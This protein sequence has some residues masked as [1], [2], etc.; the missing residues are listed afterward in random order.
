MSPP[1]SEELEAI[2]IQLLLEAVFRRYG[3]DFRNY[4]YPSIRRRV[5]STV[6]MEG[7]QT[8]SEL[9]GKLLHD[10]ACMERFLLAVSINVTTMFRDA[11]FY[12]AFQRLEG[13]APHRWRQARA[14]RRT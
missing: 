12:R 11:S 6:Y 5:W 3:F 14:G 9:Q 7:L 2:E 4:A 8:I 10:T 1:D 13:A